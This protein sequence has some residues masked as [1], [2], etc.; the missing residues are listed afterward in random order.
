MT[1][2]EAY[3]ISVSDFNNMKA[4]GKLSLRN[5]EFLTES[6]DIIYYNTP[7]KKTDL[8][9][10]SRAKQTEIMLRIK[11]IYLFE[12]NSNRKNKY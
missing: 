3:G 12:T 6:N 4:G 1:G 8:S 2:Y 7:E 5:N 11:Q 10:L 9:K